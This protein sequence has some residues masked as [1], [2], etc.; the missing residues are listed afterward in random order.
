MEHIDPRKAERDEIALK[1]KIKQDQDDADLKWLMSHKE[2]RRIVWGIFE[3]SGIMRPVFNTN[4]MQM[5]FNDGMRN[6]GVKLFA[7]VNRVC[8]DSYILMAKENKQNG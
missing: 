3:R 5:A 1:A 7:D 4:S 2:G 6:E 8:I